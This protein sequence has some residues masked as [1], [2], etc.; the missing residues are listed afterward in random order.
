MKSEIEVQIA[1]DFAGLFAVERFQAVIEAV[2]E[3]EEQVGDVTLVITDDEGIRELNRDFLDRDAATDVLAFA[4]QEQAGDFVT[5]P[6]AGAYLGDVIV[7][8]P[9]AVAQAEE[10]GHP[11]GLELD[12]LV[13]HGVLHLLGYDHATEEEKAI[14]WV[15]Q[16]AIL[17]DLRGR[18]AS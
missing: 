2:L 18:T 17:K 10:L 7:S 3:H 6:E 15:R 9:R 13:V 8:Y 4:A 1:P 11:V 12:L 14:M 5:A 16:D